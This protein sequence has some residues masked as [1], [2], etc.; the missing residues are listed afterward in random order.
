MTPIA[1]FKLIAF[2]KLIAFIIGWFL[3]LI[4]AA[5]IQAPPQATATFMLVGIVGIPIGLIWLV[6]VLIGVIKYKGE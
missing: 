3:V 1:R 4:L 2:A 5:A 6:L